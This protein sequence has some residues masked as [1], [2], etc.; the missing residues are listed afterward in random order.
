MC[1]FFLQG[2]APDPA[3]QSALIEPDLKRRSLTE[4]QLHDLPGPDLKPK[5]QTRLAQPSLPF[6]FASGNTLHFR[7]TGPEVGTLTDSKTQLDQMSAGGGAFLLTPV[8]FY[9]FLILL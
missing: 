6:T 5:T 1:Y 4:P 7:S 2:G 8:Y 3:V 9:Y